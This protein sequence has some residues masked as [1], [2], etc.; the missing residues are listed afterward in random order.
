[1]I[2][3][4]DPHTQWHASLRNRF[5]TRFGFKHVMF[6]AQPVAM[7]RNRA[8]AKLLTRLTRSDAA[9]DFGAGSRSLRHWCFD[10]CESK[11]SA[12]HLLHLEDIYELRSPK[13]RRSS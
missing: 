13:K 6:V 10:L 2:D 3:N 8:S 1:M 12:K 11:T 9:G 5:F 4:T 7:I